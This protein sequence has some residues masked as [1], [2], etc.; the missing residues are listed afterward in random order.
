M[1]RVAF[2]VVLLLLFAAIAVVCVSHQNAWTQDRDAILAPASS[3]HWAG[4]DDLGRDRAT[5]LAMAMLLGS[6]S[7]LIVAAVST[8]VAVCVALAIVFGPARVG[9]AL[10]YI[11]DVCLALPWLFLLMLVRSVLPLNLSAVACGVVT[12]A[13]L[14]LLGWPVHI[15]GLCARLQNTRDADWLFHARAAGVTGTHLALK[16]VLPHVRSVYLTQFLLGIPLCILA[17]A[18]LGALGFGMAQPLVS[19]G[20]LLQ[21]LASSAQLAATHW[22]YAPLAILLTVLLSFE[23]LS[24]ED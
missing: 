1:K 19:W 2:A 17:E 5:R 7:A 18:D 22:V 3:Q 9:F 16:F 14:S 21:D 13:L 23:F 10:R 15:R 20:T 12:L 4:T 24:V 11:S 8:T 6:A